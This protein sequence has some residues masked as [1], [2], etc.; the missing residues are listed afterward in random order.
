MRYAFSFRRGV[1]VAL[2][3]AALCLGSAFSAKAQQTFQSK[4]SNLGFDYP[5]RW[6][7]EETGDHVLLT[8]PD[9]SHYTLLRD[10]LTV[11]LSNSLASDPVMKENAAKLV[12][13][14]LKNAE[15]TGAQPLTMD[16]GAG[17]VFRFRGGKSDDGPNTT[18]YIAIVGKHSVVLLPEKAGQPGQSIGLATL[19]RTLAFQD[20]LPKPPV[21]P[22]PRP[23][24]PPMQGQ[25][26]SF[27]VM[28][29]SFQKQIAPIL[30]DKCEVCHRSRSPLGGLSVSS[31]ADFVK[32]GRNGGL[33][34]PGKPESSTLMDYLTGRRALMPKGGPPLPGSDIA[35]FRTWITEGARDDSAGA[36]TTPF[37]NPNVNPAGAGLT[38]PN[39]SA[40]GERPFRPGQM[41]RLNA[42]GR[43]I[44]ANPSG[45]TGST[46]GPTLLEAYSGHLTPTD[47]SF[48]VRLRRDGTATATWT[49]SPGRG[50][51][52]TGTYV[53]KEGNYVVTL[54]Q[55]GT[56]DAALSKTITLDLRAKGSLEV[57]YFGL[58]GAPVRRDI[59]NL[60][61][62]EIGVSGTRMGNRPGNNANNVRRRPGK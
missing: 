61:L 24:V 26:G 6:Q 12:A 4:D 28:T 10:T 42:G 37:T 38:K 39:V 57:G 45:G 44:P 60:Q 47:L 54:T 52:Y 19:F 20:S 51:Q 58:D 7:A 5:R 27:G 17:A 35:L 11:T 32:G 2:L 29:V 22:N 16:H 48:E 56:G 50:A 55:A 36:Q 46:E 41:K 34:L 23:T 21:L 14:I 13:P 30:K 49:M 1:G 62:T 33:I 43:A 53:G 8:A 3:F 15:F 40:A 18:V 9:G 59:T 25:T 31:Y